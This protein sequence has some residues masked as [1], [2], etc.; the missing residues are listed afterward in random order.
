MGKNKKREH[1]TIQHNRPFKT[2]RRNRVLTNA[3]R[4]RGRRLL[5]HGHKRGERKVISS[6][7]RTRQLK[8]YRSDNP[9]EIA[10]NF[11][12]VYGLKKEIADRLSKTIQEYM[13]M[14]L[15]ANEENETPEESHET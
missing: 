15:N 6:N 13:N 9:Q 2:G 3:K 8:V 10:E 4:P 5:Q 12:K 7:S 11:C 14:Y 1:S